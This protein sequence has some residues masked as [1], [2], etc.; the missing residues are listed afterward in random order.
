M[1]K[2]KKYLV[3]L[4]GSTTVPRDIKE[5]MD[6][7]VT[8]QKEIKHLRKL[9]TGQRVLEMTEEQALKLATEQPDLL[10]EEDEELEMFFPMPG[11]MPQVPNETEMSLDVRVVDEKTKKPV[12]DVTLY[13]L[14]QGVTYRGVTDQKGIANIK[15]YEPHLS[16]IIASPRSKYWSTFVSSPKLKEG[17]RLNMKLKKIPISGGYGWGQECLGIDRVSPFFTGKDVKI[18][19]IDSGIA[20]HEDLKIADGFNTLDG[21]DPEAWHEDENGHGTHCAGIVAAQKN[22][23]G[24][25]GVAPAAEV[26]SLKVFPGGRLSDL[27]EAIEWCINNYIDVINMSL[28][29]RSPSVHLETALVEA[30]ERGITC[31]AAAG[32][33]GGPVSY[34]AAFDT[35]IAV[36]AIGKLGSFPENSAHALKV[37]EFFGYE[38][39]VFIANFSN[40][41]SQ[42]DVCSPGV[43]ILSCVPQGYAAWDGT[44]MACPLISGLAAL[45][46]EGYPE[47]RTGDDRQPYW[48]RKILRES[49]VDIGLP[50]QMQGAGLPNAEMALAA[51]THQ[52]EYQSNFMKSYRGCL[53]SML[54]SA[55][56]Y[57]DH[58]EQAIT[59][60]D[61][62]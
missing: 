14:G 6:S 40:F 34:P 22:Q 54:T 15:I 21:Q 13:C 42:I 61:A 37:G 43:A 10:I 52:R 25:T 45:I 19:V 32:N 51:A 2:K 59:K 33:H 47:I 28:G 38:G 46:L 7:F 12:S 56:L 39:K 20:D 18:A 31:I 9:K 36:S 26:Y 41:G 44:S 48:V 3:G 27:I 35:I 1:A 5:M 62:V 58:I 24:I 53:E 4:A 55:K 29:S 23:I 60:L 30:G 50:A 16:R 57:S 49:S 8:H 11:L 17:T